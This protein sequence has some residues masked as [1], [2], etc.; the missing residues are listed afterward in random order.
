M[1]GV[2]HGVHLLAAL[3][4]GVGGALLLVLGLVHG[5]T[6]LLLQHTALPGRHLLTLLLLNILTLLAMT[7]VY[8]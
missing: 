2:T 1:Q 5:P 6:L 3:L 8:K 4:H 7:K